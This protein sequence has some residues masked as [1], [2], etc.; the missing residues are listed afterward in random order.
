MSFPLNAL[1]NWQAAIVRDT[2]RIAS[3]KPDSGGWY[4]ISFGKQ[5]PPTLKLYLGETTTHTASS[6]SLFLINGSKKAGY[7]SI[8]GH[9]K[10][11]RVK[12]VSV[13][14]IDTQIDGSKVFLIRLEP[15]RPS[16]GEPLIEYFET[17]VYTPYSPSVK[18]KED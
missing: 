18:E 6:L 17:A 2:L 4:Q 1:E 15:V 7:Q 8:S 3:G 5:S 12:Q 13:K 10:L 16:E 11:A 14:K 9:Q